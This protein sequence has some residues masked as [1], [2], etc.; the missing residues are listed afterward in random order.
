[1]EIAER[2]SKY[3]L[4]T[5]KRIPIEIKYGQGMYLVSKEGK[6]YLDMFG[7]LAVNSLGYGHKSIIEAI[8]SQCAKYI[9]LSNYFYQDSQIDLAA[10][11]VKHS[12]YKKVFFANSGTEVVE[13][14]IKIVRKWGIKAKKKNIIA[15][16]NAFHGRTLGSLSLMDKV[17]YRE[18]FGPFIDNVSS[19]IFNDIESLRKSVNEDTAAVFL[20]FIQGE[21]GINVVSDSFAGEIVKLQ[22]K[23]GFLLVADE[24]QSG[25]G[26]TGMMFAFEHFNASP[27]VVLVAKPLGGGL[28]L[29]AII[30]NEK[31]ANVLEPGNHGTT[32]GGNPVACEAG[33]AVIK[34]IA[35][36]GVMENAKINGAYMKSCLNDL[37]NKFPSSIKEVRGMGLML[38]LELHFEGERI[39]KEMRERGILINC[40]NQN[41][42]RFLP[43]LIIEKQHIDKTVY[44][45]EDV[46]KG[47][48]M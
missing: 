10:L 37:K 8:N 43:P 27:D 26:R 38:G 39:V 7:G 29:G 18:G 47:I 30:T 2:E 46:I 44:E 24:I 5:Y 14:A 9:H 34:E 21:G 35:E 32:F 17:N 22:K 23:F 48:E 4:N 31:T 15:C 16:S 42:L 12:G 19:I 40:T 25:L 33:V 20:E 36:N 6:G 1:M 28:P 41:V 11:L 13:G 45:L 3:L